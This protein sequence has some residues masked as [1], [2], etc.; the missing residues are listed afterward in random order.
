[1][2]KNVPEKKTG[3]RIVIILAVIAVVIGVA[4]AIFALYVKSIDC[5]GTY[6]DYS[7]PGG[8]IEATI[9]GF[10]VTGT[11]YQFSSADMCTYTFDFSFT[12]SPIDKYLCIK[13]AEKTDTAWST[14]ASYGHGNEIYG[15][16]KKKIDGVLWDRY[17]VKLDLN[18][19][20]K[21]SYKE[22]VRASWI[23]MIKDEWEN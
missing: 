15:D 19:N 4:Y 8:R 23:L 7:I 9:K 3:I 17:Y 5:E 12:I 1:M 14:L 11:D 22:M 6:V 18:K 16:K 10:E 13:A 2:A 21:V 20:G